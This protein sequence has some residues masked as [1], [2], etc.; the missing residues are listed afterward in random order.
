MVLYIS[1]SCGVLGQGLSN[2][3]EEREQVP[4]PFPT[5]KPGNP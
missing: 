1:L 5:D 4:F 2:T 3:R